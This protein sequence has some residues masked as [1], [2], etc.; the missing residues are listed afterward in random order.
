MA[1]PPSVLVNVLLANVLLA[2][3]LLLNL[4]RTDVSVVNS[5]LATVL[6]T[7]V[8]LTD[9]RL[10]NVLLANVL[11]AEVLL[12]KVLLAKVLLAK[13]LLSLLPPTPPALA[14]SL[15]AHESIVTAAV[16]TSKVPLM[17]D[18]NVQVKAFVALAKELLAKVLLAVMGSFWVDVERAD[19]L[20]VGLLSAFLHLVL[21]HSLS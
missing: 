19:V 7:D 8:L 5:L 13:V 17:V 14:R 18:V 12:V 2:E 1:G 4:L 3:D 15:L 9:V 20:H 11:L 21:A 16:V 6:L 10:A